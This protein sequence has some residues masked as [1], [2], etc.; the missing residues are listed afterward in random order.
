MIYNL[1][2]INN[3]GYKVEKFHTNLKLWANLSNVHINRYVHN[4]YVHS[5][6]CYLLIKHLYILLDCEILLI[7]QYKCG[8]II[9][10]IM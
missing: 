1:Y 5:S 10:M 8:V 6:K 7:T 4:T 3:T 9:I 2:I